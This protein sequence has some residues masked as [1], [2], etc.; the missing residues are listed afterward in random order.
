VAAGWHPPII[1]R[2]KERTSIK[3][4][5]KRGSCVRV[6][7]FLGGTNIRAGPF[8]ARSSEEVVFSGS[9]DPLN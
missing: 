2:G 7:E 9:K 3:R 6:G 1:R 4:E 5:E 8:R